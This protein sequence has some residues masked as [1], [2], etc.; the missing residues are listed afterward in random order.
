MNCQGQRNEKKRPREQLAQRKMIGRPHREIQQHERQETQT[1]NAVPARKSSG[2][3][4]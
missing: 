3:V 2:A 1:K 4:M